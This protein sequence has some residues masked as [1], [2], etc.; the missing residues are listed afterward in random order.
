VRQKATTEKKLFNMKVLANTL[1]A[2]L[3][4]VFSIFIASILGAALVLASFHSEFFIG[5]IAYIASIVM[6]AAGIYAAKKWSN[7]PLAHIINIFVTSL[8]CITFTF[9][10]TQILAGFTFRYMG[11]FE[12]KLLND[13]AEKYALPGSE[14]LL[15]AWTIMT[16][17]CLVF[18]NRWANENFKESPI[19]VKN[20]SAI[21]RLCSLILWLTSTPTNIILV[22]LLLTGSLWLAVVHKDITIFAA[23]GGPVTIIGL[24]STIQFTTLEKYLKLEELVANSTGVTGPPISEDDYV[25]IIGQN[26][27]AARRRLGLELKSEL[28]GIALTVFGTLLWAYGT[29]VP[30]TSWIEKLQNFANLAS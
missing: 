30:I 24:F 10:V 2:A 7:G 15:L 12:S 4:D 27:D 28:T 18:A 25:R 8:V 13:F 29:Y 20:H 14:G 16:S 26:Q 6:V 5:F 1:K 19:P 3:M 23:A 9:N 11:G 22:A 17:F 21:K